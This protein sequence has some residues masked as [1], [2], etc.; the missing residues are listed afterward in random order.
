MLLVSLMVADVVSASALAGSCCLCTIVDKS[1]VKI[2]KETC[3]LE[4][5]DI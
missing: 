1:F 4:G 3:E 2:S 5:D